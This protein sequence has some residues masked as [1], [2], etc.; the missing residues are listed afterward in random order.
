MAKLSITEAAR[1]CN[2]ARTTIQRAVKTGRLSLD[3]EHR[4]DTAEL[5]RVGYQLDAAVLHA[6][7]QQD[8]TYT[9]HHAAPQHSTMPQ[10]DAA[11]QD[12]RLLRHERDALQRE[13]D[14]LMQQ[15][16]MLRSMHQTT[17]QQLT[18]AQQ[19]LHEMQHRY[20]RLL[21]APRPPS[22]ATPA[23]QI[24]TVLDA[25]RG[26]MRRRIL[27]LLQDH[28]AGLSPAQTRQMLGVD[29]TLQSRC[30]RW[31]GMRCSGASRQACMCGQRRNEAETA[32][33]AGMVLVG[34]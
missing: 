1:I 2:V 31:S 25:P 23:A 9:Q 32:V 8:T 30:R 15:L 12:L 24:P 28:P 7:S 22:P 26:E 10:Q 18:Q 27:A 13:R 29:K 4:V 11:P 5:L 33:P 20:D 34:A 3:A 19:V 6:A 14:L 17:Q 16:D 21:E